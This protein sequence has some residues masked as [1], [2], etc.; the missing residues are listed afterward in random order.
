MDTR[1]INDYLQKSGDTELPDGTIEENEHGFCVW[2]TE[3]GVLLLVAVYGDGTHWNNW[4]TNKANE[5]NVKQII[6]ATKRKPGAF[7]RKH[8]FKVTGYILARAI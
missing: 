8:G 6:F 5:L 2:R 7:I 3:D 4:A 1:L